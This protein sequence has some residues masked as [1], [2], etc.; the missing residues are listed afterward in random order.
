MLIIEAIIVTVPCVL[1]LILF[2]NKP[3]KPPSF[4]ASIEK[5]SDYIKD[6]KKLFSNKNYLMLLLSISM[7]YGTLTA[8]TTCIEYV[9]SPFGFEKPEDVSSLMLV[10]AM[11]AGFVGSVFFIILLKKSL[12]YKKILATGTTLKIQL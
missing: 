10:C 2:R 8:F 12:A 9:A 7:S 3:S 5:D 4:A 11:V 6:L 1:T